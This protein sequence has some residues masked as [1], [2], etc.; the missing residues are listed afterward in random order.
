MT[1]LHHSEPMRNLGEDQNSGSRRPRISRLLR[2]ASG[3]PLIRAH[4]VI[5]LERAAATGDIEM[6]ER[7]GKELVS[8]MLA[9][10][11][12]DAIASAVADL[13]AQIFLEHPPLAQMTSRPEYAPHQVTSPPEAVRPTNE[14]GSHAHRSQHGSEVHESRDWVEYRLGILLGGEFRGRYR[15]EIIEI[16]HDVSIGNAKHFLA[17]GRGAF[18]LAS[19]LDTPSRRARLQEAIERFEDGISKW[20][21]GNRQD[22]RV[23]WLTLADTDRRRLSA[24]LDEADDIFSRYGGVSE[25]WRLFAPNMDKWLHWLSLELV[26]RIREMTAADFGFLR[27]C[28]YRL[29]V[30]WGL[31]DDIYP[32]TQRFPL[33]L[34]ELPVHS[35]YQFESTAVG[36]RNLNA[37]NSVFCSNLGHLAAFDPE[38]WRIIHRLRPE[39]WNRLALFFKR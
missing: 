36:L 5:R 17:T 29:R 26:H 18:A 16:G 9:H 35:L 22:P 19:T 4:N 27:R 24:V 6:L 2:N 10:D 11:R 25:S 30:A 3:K 13:K 14:G 23:T 8:K 12:R 15:D 20:R 31:T 34:A 39:V 37:L 21:R 1:G 28:L 7:L 33:E 38:A 32:W